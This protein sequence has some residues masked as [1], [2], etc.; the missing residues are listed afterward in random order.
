MFF[1]L[2]DVNESGHI[3]RVVQQ[4]MCLY[5]ALGSALV[6]PCD[7]K[8]GWVSI[9]DLLYGG[10]P[11]RYDPYDEMLFGLCGPPQRIK[12]P[13]PINVPVHHIVTAIEKEGIITL[14]KVGR[15][16]EVT[17]GDEKVLYPRHT[18]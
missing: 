2:A 14:D 10:E 9:A 12:I 17:D 4:Y 15:P 7:Q 13:H 18:F 1:G 11:Y 3:V 5:A 8:G 16:I 6:P